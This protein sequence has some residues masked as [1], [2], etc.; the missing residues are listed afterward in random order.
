[1]PTSVIF[2]CPKTISYQ[3]IFLIHGSGTTSYPLIF[4]NKHSF[5]VQILYHN[6]ICITLL[7]MY[8]N[9]NTYNNVVSPVRASFNIAL[10][11]P[12]ASNF[13]ICLWS[14]IS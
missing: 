13:E 5:Y 6:K 2:I 8:N 14:T 4:V 3:A 11:K 12:S 9:K 1:M 10:T 7:V